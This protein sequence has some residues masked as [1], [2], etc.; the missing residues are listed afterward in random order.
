M[1]ASLV[2]IVEGKITHL[3]PTE[4][5]VPTGAQIIDGNGRL[6]V[7]GF[8]DLQINGAFGGDFTTQPESIWQAAKELTRYGVTSFLPTIVTSPL[9]AVDAARDI[10]TFGQ[11]QDFEG[12]APLG[13]H[14]EGPFLNP[15]KKGAHPKE[16]IRNPLL[17]DVVDWSPA[18]GVRMVTLAPELPGAS[19][20][21]SVLAERGIL[22]AA[23][24]SMASYQEAKAAINAGVRYG[25]HIFN[26]MPPFHQREPGL[27]GAILADERVTAGLIADGLHVHP[28]IIKAIWQI[29]LD[30]RLNL[31][32]DA[33]AAL[34]MPDG[35]YRLG[36]LTVNVDGGSCRLPDGTLAGST[37]S[38]DRG[39][40]NLMKYTGCSLPEALR[41]VTATPAAL[42]GLGRQKGQIDIGYDADLVLLDSDYTVDKTIVAGKVLYVK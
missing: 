12:A 13:L 10:I 22:V 21:C 42:L 1:T 31:V 38:L 30:G 33:I 40:K 26:A 18:T 15:L 23:G 39:L 6:L 14:L 28:G 17:E 34:G 24:H 7:P 25:T 20:I 8:I 3:G 27:V 37:L 41:T 2:I 11:P 32:T 4:G 35:E 19:W 16:F 9:A 29:T 5:P 36:K